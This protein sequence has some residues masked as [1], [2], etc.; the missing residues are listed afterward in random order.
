[1]QSRVRGGQRINRTEKPCRSH[2]A[3]LDTTGDDAGRVVAD[4]RETALPLLNALESQTS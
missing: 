4:A 1:M 3:P 2:Q